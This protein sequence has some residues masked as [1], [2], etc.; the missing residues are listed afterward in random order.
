M[1]AHIIYFFVSLSCTIIS[2]Q[3]YE[4]N[5]EDEDERP[6]VLREN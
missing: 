3:H 6:E 4:S 2:L 1:L 5:Y